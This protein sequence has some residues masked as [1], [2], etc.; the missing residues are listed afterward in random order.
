MVQGVGF[1]PFVFQQARRHG[2][3]G[4]VS[5]NSAGVLIDVEGPSTAIEAFT[6]ELIDK[7]PPLAHIVAVRVTETSPGGH[8]SF[9]IIKSS[10]TAEKTTLI[11][12]D[13][14]VCDDCLRE[15]R[16]PAD[17]RYRYPFINCTNCG[18]RYTI[19]EDVPYDRPNTTMRRF[20]MCADCQAEY[21]NPADRRF[22]AQPNACPLCG[23]RVTLFDNRRRRVNGDD[24]IAAARRQLGAGK[25][26]AVK[27]L[28]GYHLAG[29]CRRAKRPWRVCAA[30][31]CAK[32][33]RWP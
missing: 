13:T 8:K 33:N 31:S 1:R 11:S 22:H 7:A 19:I 25:I 2:L 6:G 15:Q 27:G 21:E 26:V 29:R 4:Q 10:T 9:V 18:P 3:A 14:T 28:G 24:P 23:P 5:N 30:A 32:K 16:D 12:P 20:E 17:R